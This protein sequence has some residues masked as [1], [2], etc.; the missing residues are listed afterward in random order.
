LN[1]GSNEATCSSFVSQ[2]IRQFSRRPEPESLRAEQW[3]HEAET[4]EILTEGSDAGRR[5]GRSRMI[6]DFVIQVLLK[7]SPKFRNFAWRFEPYGCSIRDDD[8]VKVPAES[9]APFRRFLQAAI[10]RHLQEFRTEVR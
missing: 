6:R 2:P 3:L 4:R 8:R 7:F 1:Y 9:I 10:M 5:F